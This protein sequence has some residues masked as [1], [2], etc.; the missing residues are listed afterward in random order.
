MYKIDELTTEQ[1]SLFPYFVDKWTKIGLCTQ[2]IN[3]ELSK[4]AINK[5]YV[6]GKLK[7][8][9][10]IIWCGSPLSMLLSKEILCKK[11][12]LNKKA[13][14]RASVRDSV[15]DSV[16]DSVR[17]SV[18]D[19]VWDSVRDSVRASV[20]AS[21]R[22]S[23]RASVRDSVYG[24]HEAGWLSFYDYF[25]QV[26][27]LEKQTTLLL[28]LFYLAKTTGWI[29]P[30]KNICF[31]SERHNVLI[32]DKEGRLHNR[33]GS[34]VVYPDG[35]KIY[36]VH[37]IRV[38]E[39]IIE[40]SEK[41][42]VK[43]IDREHNVELRRILIEQYGQEKY[44]QNS[45]AEIVSKDSCGILYRKEIK[46]DEPIVMV[47]VINSTLE[48]DGKVKEYFLRVPKDMQSAKEAVAWTFNMKPEDYLPMVET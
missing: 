23:V 9:D 17:D 4:K 37:G 7:F 21:V 47:K 11:L 48:S 42:N 28:G 22:D 36:A 24:S 20:R 35:W 25:R 13:S 45:K 38:P 15:G 5:C 26:I 6:S 16:W 46:N 8:P 31:A 19:S 29:L 10:K 39:W 44:L 40:S 18:G 33:K 43:I 27:G 3:K 2:P 32:R 30:Y 12:K 14:V 34:S 41:I 1:K